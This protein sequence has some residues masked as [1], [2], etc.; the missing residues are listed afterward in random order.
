MRQKKA[1]HMYKEILAGVETG[2][3]YDRQG[4]GWENGPYHIAKGAAF[5]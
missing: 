1:S 4:D 3:G 5:V 2:E